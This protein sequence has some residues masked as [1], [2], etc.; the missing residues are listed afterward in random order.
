LDSKK[1]RRNGEVEIFKSACPY[2]CFD[3]CSFEV[4][5]SK[6]K[7]IEI[8]ANSDAEVTGNFICKKG[9]SHQE[10]MYRPDRLKFPLL[11]K[12]EGF[13]R[14][15]WEE[16][17]EIITRKIKQAQQTYGLTSVGCLSG[18]GA[19]GKLKGVHEVFFAHLGGYTDF[20]GSI[21]WGAGIEATNMDFGKTLG[22]HPVDMK[23]SNIIVLWGRNPIETN[24]HLVPYIKK[25]RERGCRVYLIDPI[26][27]KSSVLA[28]IHIKLKPDS[29]WAF[30]AACIINCIKK[31]RLVRA[32]IKNHLNDS[33]GIIDYLSRFT[34]I[35]YKVLL[36]AAGVTEEIVEVFT[37][38]IFENSPSTCYIGYGPQR[39]K[40]GGLNI[41]TIN[42]LWAI[43]GNIG[44]AG[45]GANYAN[46]TNKGRF[47]FSF[48]MPK[49]K[50]NVRE[51]KQGQFSEGLLATDPAVKVLFISCINP[52]SQLS[53]SRGV[54]R[55]LENIP[56]KIS[57]EQFMTDTAAMCELVLPVTYF[58]ESEDIIT[59]G[60]WNSSF[61]YVA[62]CVEPLE[63]CKA[64]FD[65]FRELAEKLGLK[66]YP[67]L[68]AAAWLEKGMKNLEAYGLT[69]EKLKNSGYAESPLQKQIQW[70]DN[71]F[72]NPDGKFH[73]FSKEQL[74]SRINRYKESSEVGISSY[75]NLI[76]VH[77]GDQINSQH[78]IVLQ[79]Q[80][81][82]VLY[83][84]PKTAGVFGLSEGDSAMAIGENGK[85]KVRISITKKASP[86]A[87][88]TKQGISYADQGSINYLTP[89]GITDIGDQALLNEIKI[90]LE[91]L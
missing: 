31:G 88:Y 6:G 35:D 78:S 34:E 89:S 83:I 51:I 20:V 90:R 86:Y 48:A 38:D 5:V 76:T 4:H 91:K 37:K 71:R 11:K 73:A 21:C 47:D 19:A 84:H 40:E 22:H 9:M 67:Q 23:N 59:S 13:I 39:Y 81:M 72:D 30:G 68:D 18:G 41:R 52:V 43:T 12:S 60:M 66:E 85:L 80:D 46:Q 82:P 74:K 25:A 56:F 24:I 49:A 33:T 27:S 58:T 53:N 62:K 15:S 14:I 32:F 64:E 55:A 69:F 2:D 65:I 26:E 3:C 87:A 61:K 10:R 8:T 70:E 44:I 36:A 1:N 16:A 29:D 42:L 77:W 57:L 45:G 17:Y 28:D 54:I 7:V 63:E 75:V 79:G 50:P